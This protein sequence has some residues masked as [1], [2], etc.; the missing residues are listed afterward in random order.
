MELNFKINL[1]KYP[2]SNNNS[3]PLKLSFMLE[4]DDSNQSKDNINQSNINNLNVNNN[5]IIK[6]NILNNENNLGINNNNIQNR[7]NDNNNRNSKNEN[8]KL[9]FELNKKENLNNESIINS[10]AKNYQKLKNDLIDTKK[11]NDVK[12][13]TSFNRF[14]FNS[15]RSKDNDKSD[16]L[17]QYNKNEMPKEACQALFI[18][19]ITNEMDDKALKKAFYKYGTVIFCKIFKDKKTQ[20]IK[21]GM[22]NFK[23]VNSAVKAMN[24]NDNIFCEGKKL[25]ISYHKFYK[26]PNNFNKNNREKEGRNNYGEKNNNIYKDNNGSNNDNEN[27]EIY[28]WSDFEPKSKSNSNSNSGN[29]ELRSRNKSPNISRNRSRSR[30]RSRSDSRIKSN[31]SKEINKKINDDDEW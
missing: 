20:K 12:S 6:L 8:S 2:F 17:K 18:R 27:D 28:S 25:T 11:F 15:N 3:T 14:K 19:G 13:E 22:V 5:N 29:F 10:G 4:F 23:D 26:K 31:K 1:S 9:Q 21:G 30:S 16:F 24:D 7:I